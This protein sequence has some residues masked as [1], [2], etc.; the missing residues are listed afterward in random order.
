MA[1]EYFHPCDDT[2]FSE[3]VVASGDDIDTTFRGINCYGNYANE[4][5]NYTL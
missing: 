2:Q 5:N 4:V 3:V 1:S